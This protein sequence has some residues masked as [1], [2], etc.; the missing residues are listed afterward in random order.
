MWRAGD[1]RQLSELTTLMCSPLQMSTLHVL[2]DRIW[3]PNR[4]IWW[5]EFPPKK[6]PLI[7]LN[8]WKESASAVSMGSRMTYPQPLLD[9]GLAAIEPKRIGAH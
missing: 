2:H 4:N 8:L 5:T 7:R 3:E 6:E 9:V 1:Y